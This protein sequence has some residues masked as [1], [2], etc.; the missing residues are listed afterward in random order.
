MRGVAGAQTA[1]WLAAKMVGRWPNGDPLTSGMPRT[2]ATPQKGNPTNDFGYAQK[3]AGGLGCPVAAHVRRA[4]PSD[5]LPPD[6]TRSLKTVARHRILRRGRSF[7]KPVDET[8]RS[9]EDGV[10]RGLYFVALNA[11]LRRQF[12]FVQ[13]TWLGNPNFGGLQNDGDPLLGSRDARKDDDDSVVPAADFSFPAAPYRRRLS[14]LP[15]FVQNRGGGYFFVPGMRALRYLA[16]AGGLAARG[17]GGKRRAR[18]PLRPRSAPVLTA[19]ASR[20]SPCQGGGGGRW[21]HGASQADPPGQPGGPGDALGQ[22]RRRAGGGSRSIPGGSRL[23]GPRDVPLRLRA[24]PLLRALR[25]PH[26]AAGDRQAG[27]LRGPPPP[28]ERSGRLDAFTTAHFR[29]ACRSSCSARSTRA[30]STAKDAHNL[31]PRPGRPATSP[32]GSGRPSRAA[33][34]SRAG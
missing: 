7:G 2:D 22:L 27:P 4:N 34:P 20:C 26:P 32:R 29:T 18:L 30:A 23:S 8:A 14:G 11:D 1:E 16:Q 28:G 33:L 13:Q 9:T 21:R 10:D 12:E 3:D 25:Q 24:A 5:S 31:A 17:A 6:P 15:R 19:D